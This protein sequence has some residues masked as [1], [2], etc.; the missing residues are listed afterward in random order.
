MTNDAAVV[1]LAAGQGTRMKSRTA[2]VLHRAG[3]KPLVRQAID[4]AL[5]IAPPNRIFVVVGY[6]AEQVRAEVEAAGVQAIHQSEQLGTGHA[7]RCGEEKLATLGG[8]LIVFVGDCPLIQA[9]TL[10]QLANRQRADQAGATVITTEVDD[11][12][13]YGRIIR[14]T[15][16]NVC[17]IV[18]HKAATPEQLAVREINSGI[19]CFDA[20][21]LWRHIHELCTDNPA[22]EYYL[23]DMVAILIRAGSRVTAMKIP[24]ASELLGINNR[25]ELAEADRI[26]RARK[27]R[28]LMLDGVTIEKP[29]TVTIDSD[30]EIGMDTIVGPFAQITGRSSIGQGCRVGAC[31]IVHG[32]TLADG[33]EV[34][35]FSMI[36]DSKL[37]ANAHVGPYGRLRMGAHMGE[38]A[39]VGNFVELKNT[40]LGAGSKS[41]HLAYLGDSMIGGKVNVG[42]GSI[43]C[44]YDGHRKHRTAIGDGAFI[45][46]NSTLIAPVEIG[47]GAYIAAGSVINQKVPARA[48]GVG[49][50]RQVNKEGWTKRT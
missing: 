27:V 42:A 49:R 23:T 14:N 11:P 8:S 13:G 10:R 30:V 12:T 40:A 20:A 6:Q 4:T 38:G 5:G 34:F 2:K 44:N 7:V 31:S 9:E 19:L 15:D 21:L 18:E 36:S 24:D 26:L 46:S 43:T 47:E 32:S 45:G 1:I 48:L 33:A 17:E 22:G 3:G 39:H 29:E 50:S 37:D 16:G 25:V 28:Q 41:M 35:P